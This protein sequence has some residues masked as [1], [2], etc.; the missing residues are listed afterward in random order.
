LIAVRNG[1]TLDA[2]LEGRAALRQLLFN[3]LIDAI[4]D[5]PRATTR[6]KIGAIA[7]PV[8]REIE[9]AVDH[10]AKARFRIRRNPGYRITSGAGNPKR[11]SPS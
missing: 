8:I 5:A 9:S 2:S 10:N 7:E 3:P 4:N 1:A 6:D 11:P